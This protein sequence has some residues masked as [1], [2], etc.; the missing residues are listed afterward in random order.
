MDGTRIRRRKDP[1]R[2]KW[3]GRYRQLRFTEHMG[4]PIVLDQRLSRA[5]SAVGDRTTCLMGALSPCPA[6]R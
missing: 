5:E 3:Y 4:F 6:T 1:A 2:Q